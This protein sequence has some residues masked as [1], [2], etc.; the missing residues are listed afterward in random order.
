[1]FRELPSELNFEFFPRSDG[2]S[3]NKGLARHFSTQNPNAVY[4]SVQIFISELKIKR[5]MHDLNSVYVYSMV[6]F[7]Q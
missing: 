7:K 1:V 2:F 6:R 5:F 3:I 4:L